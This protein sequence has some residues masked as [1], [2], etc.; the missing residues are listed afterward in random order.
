MGSRRGRHLFHLIQEQGYEGSYSHLARLL[1]G[2]RRAEKQ[3]AGDPVN[4]SPRLTPVR[5]PQTGHAIS[6]VIAAALCIKPRGAL[7][8]DQARKVDAL[9]AESPSFTMMRSLAMRFKGILR[10]RQSNPLD[11]WID[12]AIETNIIGS[13]PG[14]GVGTV[15]LL[16]RHSWCRLFTGR[17][18]SSPHRYHRTWRSAFPPAC[19]GVTLPTRHSVPA[20]AHRRG[21]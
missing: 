13:A 4:S 2:W 5:D 9:K 17:R 18:S 21:G 11:A 14:G 12:N 16:L 10:G 6:P 15:V 3:A 19:S 7:T 8:S 1:A 20:S